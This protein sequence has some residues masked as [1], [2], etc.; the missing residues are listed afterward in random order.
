M[1]ALP[2]AVI[3]YG[4][5]IDHIGDQAPKLAARRRR[6][7]RGARA[8]QAVCARLDQAARAGQEKGCPHKFVI[9][10]IFALDVVVLE[11]SATA[12][13]IS[14]DLKDQSPRRLR[15]LGGTSPPPRS[16]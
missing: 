4:R 2:C 7:Q 6:R 5:S 12:P 9:I 16:R 15:W 13:I 1:A 8:I 10:T 14:F 11:T 3:R